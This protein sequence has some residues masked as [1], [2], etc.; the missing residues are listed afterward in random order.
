MKDLIRRWIPRPLFRLALRRKD[1]RALRRV[2]RVDVD[3][4]PLK[5]GIDAEGL[6][7]VFASPAHAS[8]W[9]Q[10]AREVA[11]LAITER[12][13]GV[14]AGDR[15]AVF[16]LI[17]HFRPRTVLEVGTHIGASTVHVAQALLRNRA[18]A[19]EYAPELTTVDIHDVNDPAGRPWARWGST[20]S[21][22]EMMEKIG[23]AGWVR[24]VAQ[25]S[26]AFLAETKD[27]Y[28]FIFLDGDHAGA[29]VYQELPAALRR[30]NPGGVVLLHDYF[31]HLK[32]LWSDGSVIPGPWQGVQRLV[33][34]GARFRVLPL[35]EL[36]WPTK[37]GSRVT[38]LALVVGE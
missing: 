24:F 36:P 26:L 14:N 28:D 27:T 4:A 16:A 2:A 5:R 10:V 18:D 25:P 17:R 32:P 21:P 15:R 9:P 19:P 38:S 31:P 30:L 23:A 34:E 29:T 1:L 11:A 35:G 22:R 12:A 37:Q 3:A 13:L 8:E 20:Y 33:S 7:A 6:R